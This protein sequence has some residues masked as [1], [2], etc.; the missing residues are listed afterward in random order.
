MIE[1]S[2]VDLAEVVCTTLQNAGSVAGLAIITE[3]TIVDA[4]T[5]KRSSGAGG[6]AM[7][8]MVS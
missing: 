3:G 7:N 4:T 5:K 2:I 6:D 1:A 8:G